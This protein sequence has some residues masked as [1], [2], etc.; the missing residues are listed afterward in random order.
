[1]K[2]YGSQTLLAAWKVPTPISKMGGAIEWDHPD[3]NAHKK[4][5]K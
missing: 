3:K 5:N 1:M 2:S 4:Q